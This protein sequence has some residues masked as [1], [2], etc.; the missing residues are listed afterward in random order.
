MRHFPL[1]LDLQGRDVLLLGE[2]EALAAKA[3]LLT[4]AGA[5]LREASRFSPALLDGVALACAAGAP[6]DELRALSAA[7]QARGI[8]VNV[9][10]R[11]AL[12]SFVTPAVIDR[13]PV[14]VAIGTAGTAPLLARLIRQR[15]EAVL[16]PGLGR[17]AALAER[18]RGPLREKLPELG[19]RRRFLERVFSGRPA[20][21]AEEG[22]QAEAEAAFAAALEAAETA[23][24]GMVHLVG[25]GPGAADLLT[26][27]A[28]RLMGEADVVVHDRLVSA[29]VLDLARR[30]AD[31]I[32]VGKSRGAHSVPQEEINALL[33]RLARTGRKVVRLK[34]GDPFVFGRGG[35]EIEALAEAGIAF[36]V[37]PG[38]TAAL[39]CAAQAGIPLT[40]R[41]AARS[42]T[43]VTGHT[44]DGRL[45]VDFDAL[46][47]PGQTIAVYMG[48]TTLPQFFAGLVAA[49]AD[50]TT[51][52]AFI[53]RGG[54]PDQRML[55]GSFAE[56]AR[57]AGGWVGGGPALLLLGEAC[58]RS[59]ALAGARATMAPQ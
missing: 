2:G 9:V 22:R 51:P 47:R 3:R 44:S 19:A 56:V 49:G 41:E 28:L 17:I 46:A 35:E 10:D 16:S 52:A 24:A 33:V 23:T 34:G 54:S 31:R 29:A 26:L 25:A 55:L 14:T 30:D 5:R 53:E 48:V 12:S 11:P 32:D 18:F 57:D 39:A 38:I 42:V 50:P 6:E 7:C 45:A 8:P 58:G 21:L 37:V 15:I 13:D 43:F 59:P 4:A 40:H 27:R 36:E 1:F 20:Q